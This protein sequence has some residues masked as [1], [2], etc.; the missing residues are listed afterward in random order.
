MSL[1]QAGTLAD[2]D[3]EADLHLATE[4][5]DGVGVE[6]TV[7]P[8]RDLS[9]GPGITHPPQGFAQEVS[10][11]SGGVGPALPEPGHEHLTG[12]SGHGEERVIAPLAGVAVVSGALLGQAIGLA[13]GGVQVDGERPVAGTSPRARVAGKSSPVL[14]TRRWSSKAI[15]M[16]SGCSSGSICWVL[17]LSGGFSVQKPLSQIQR[18]TSH[19]FSTPLFSTPS[20]D[21]G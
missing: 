8:H 4:G 10:S 17:L 15:W 18:S 9:R 12:A 1:A 19:R 6:A 3:G 7:G 2:G 13:D 14:L 5:N 11:D 16:R 21:S 20:V